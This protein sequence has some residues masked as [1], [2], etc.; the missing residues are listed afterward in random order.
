MVKLATSTTVWS[1]IL[2]NGTTEKRH[3]FPRRPWCIQVYN[4][5][6]FLTSY[7]EFDENPIANIGLEMS[8]YNCCIV[9][10]KKICL[11]YVGCYFAEKDR[12]VDIKSLTSALLQ[13]LQ[14]YLLPYA[15]AVIRLSLLKKW[16]AVHY[17][18]AARFRYQM[19]GRPSGQCPPLIA[20][21]Y[22]LYSGQTRLQ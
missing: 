14:L 9:L 20:L 21:E 12:H 18:T 5:Y 13:R 3:P 8:R 4:R 10:K 2:R 15:S 1:A 17:R 6:A 16:C 7:Q 22:Q 19:K 11:L